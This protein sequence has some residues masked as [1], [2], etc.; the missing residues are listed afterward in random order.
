VK[1]ANYCKSIDVLTFENH[2]NHDKL[3]SLPTQI[4][5]FFGCEISPN[6]KK[7][8]KVVTYTK[9]C[10]KILKKNYQKNKGFE[11]GSPNLKCLL[12][13]VAKQHH[14][15]NVLLSYL[16]C[17]HLMLNLESWNGCQCATLEN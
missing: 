9:V 8:F 2:D 6:C 14:D 3:C 13:Q 5:H 15:H 11:L 4:Q 1:S 16:S 7:T 17:C 10:F 12:L